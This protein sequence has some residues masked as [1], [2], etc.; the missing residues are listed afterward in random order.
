[1][2]KYRIAW[3]PGDGVGV[4]VMDAAQ[5]VLDAIKLDAEYVPAD[6]G[7]EFW[8]KEGDPLP[9][10]TIALLE[11]CTCGLFGAITSKPTDEAE[12]ELAP[13]LKGKELSYRSPIVRLRQHL[14][15]R[16]KDYPT[17]ARSSVSVSI[18]IYIQTFDL[19]RHTRAA[20]LIIAMTS[21][22]SSSGRTPRAC[23]AGSNFIL[24]QRKCGR[25]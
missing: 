10:R 1:M 18:S 8:C 25:Q 16:A 6:I 11:D 15:S 24:S 9:E 19:A 13:E 12:L 4:D 2:S 20:R 21:T 7:W 17:E 23:T 14:N 3:M 5:I 22:W